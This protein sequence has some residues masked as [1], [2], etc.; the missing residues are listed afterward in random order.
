MTQP[1]YPAQGSQTPI[2]APYSDL[3]PY[4]TQNEA[5]HGIPKELLA[6]IAAQ[7]VLP[8]IVPNGYS[9]R[10]ALAPLRGA[11]GLVVCL[12]ESPAGDGAPMHVHEL[13]LENFFCLS[14][15]FR[16]DWE[17]DEGRHSKVLEPLDYCAIPT[18][19]MRSFTNISS[20]PGRM[21]AVVHIQG[22][23][24]GDPIHYSNALKEEVA[25]E[26]GSE[27]I[28]SLRDIGMK[29]EDAS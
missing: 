14:G 27:M 7:R 1:Q 11:P 22:E 20:E 19:I 26:Y 16:V 15:R 18:G 13:G 28:Q 3:K 9:G 12:I 10:Q 4:Q 2:F 24:Q 5:A 25:A 6:K 21:L 8:I 23:T 29:F 17:N